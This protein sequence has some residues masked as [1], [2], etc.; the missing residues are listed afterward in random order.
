MRKLPILFF[1]TFGASIPGIA[2]LDF[3]LDKLSN[4]GKVFNAGDGYVSTINDIRQIEKALSLIN[5]RSQ[6]C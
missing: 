2:Q 1:L 4:L 3:F 5:E 6:V